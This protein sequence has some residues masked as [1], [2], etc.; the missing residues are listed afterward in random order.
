MGIVIGSNAAGR[1]KTASFRFSSM[2]KW[3]LLVACVAMWFALSLG[4]AHAQTEAKKPLPVEIGTAQNGMCGLVTL[5]APLCAPMVLTLAATTGYGYTESLG[6]V[7]GGH[8]RLIGI[9]GAGFA[10]L[11]WLSVGLALDGRIDIHPED[12]LGKNTTATG[13]P[14]IS[15]RGGQVL[16]KGFTIG[17]EATL[18]F[19][20]N[21]APSFEIRATTL[22]LKTLLSWAPRK[23]P[24]VLLTNVGFRIDSSGN[25]SPDLERTRPGDR[26]ALGISDSHAFLLG[27]GGAYR[28]TPLIQVFGEFS[29]DFLFGSK[30]PRMGESPLRLAAGGRYLFPEYKLAAEV[31]ITTLLSGRPGLKPTD[32]LVPTDPRI[33]FTAGVR[34]NA[35]Q[36]PE[37]PKEASKGAED[38]SRV[39]LKTTEDVSGIVLDDTGAPLPEAVVKVVDPNAETEISVVTNSNGRYVL[40]DLPFGT[41]TLEASAVGFAP[42]TWE[43]RVYAEMPEQEPRTLAPQTND[44]ALL[45]GLVRSFGSTPL[46]AQITITDQR[47]RQ[48]AR[49]TTD[50]QGRF[51]VS[52]RQGTYR[53]VV[54]ANGYKQHRGQVHIVSGGVSILNVDMRQE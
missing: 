27:V 49:I 20:G 24:Y 16:P 23:Q 34:Y 10:P 7:P 11:P 1:L 9:V 29:A 18:W 54:K 36:P 2:G 37:A 47:G 17:G 41:V 32:P 53:V 8:H 5:G 22:D 14:R 48:A 44:G 38:A 26:I 21:N 46:I 33:I 30:A 50:E 4:S 40:K 31:A 12:S 35:W 25:S 28:V 15:A 45:R 43:T 52:L 6:S 51:E 39:V 42:Q 19:P 13:N 3:F